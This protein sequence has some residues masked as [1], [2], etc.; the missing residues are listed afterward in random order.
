MNDTLAGASPVDQP[1]GRLDPERCHADRDGDCCHANC[2]Q[3]R[4]NE[5]HTTG[6]HCP[7]DVHDDDD[8]WLDDAEPDDLCLHCRGDGMDPDCDYL[9]PCPDCG[10][11]Q[12]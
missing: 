12:P 4:D 3:L 7:L 9:L 2:P 1:V 6:R 10:G 5:P 8:S 11:P